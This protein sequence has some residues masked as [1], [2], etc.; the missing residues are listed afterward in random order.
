[1]LHL[2][3]SSILLHLI[4]DA[5]SNKNQVSKKKLIFLNQYINYQQL[6]DRP[7]FIIAKNTHKYVTITE[8]LQHFQIWNAVNNEVQVSRDIMLLFW[9]RFLVF[10]RSHLNSNTAL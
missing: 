10:Q 5:R 4:D 2:V 6:H 1:L 9:K 7:N 8:F 3:G